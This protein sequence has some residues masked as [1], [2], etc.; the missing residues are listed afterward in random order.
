[1]RRGLI[2]GIPCVALCG[3]CGGAGGAG[4]AGEGPSNK[5]LFGVKCDAFQAQEA[6]DLMAWDSAARANLDRLRKSGVVVVRYEKKGCDVQLELLPSCKASGTYRYAGYSANETK[7]AKSASEL[8]AALPLGASALAGKM[9]QGQAMRTD[10]MLVGTDSLK[11]DARISRAQLRGP[12]CERAT[13]VVS[14]VYLGGFALAVGKTVELEGK[15]SVFGVGAGA[16]HSSSSERVAS[17]GVADACHEAQT[18][19]KESKTCAVPLRV[20]LLALD[21]A[22]AGPAHAATPV[23]GGGPRTSCPAGMALIA[24][25]PLVSGPAKERHDVGAFCVD[26]TEVTSAEYAACVEKK[27]CMAPTS[28]PASSGQREFCNYRKAG[29]EKHP[30]N[31]VTYEEAKTY[32]TAQGKALPTEQELE[33]AARG[34]EQRAL[35]W[36]DATTGARACFD[37]KKEGTCEVG[38][39]PD[40]AT[41][42]GVLDLAGNVAEIADGATGGQIRFG[43]HYAKTSLRD[44]EP[45]HKNHGEGVGPEIGFRCVAR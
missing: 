32:C 28:G 3:A 22:T 16:S 40:G 33:L 18:S 27:Q 23:G 42:E 2:I 30:I 8:F 38:A 19:G 13:H 29:R 12:E 5:E 9:S 14:T 4:L 21:K 24:A 26:K 36:G 10:Y 25:A 11:A 45:T 17:E 31:C 43:G 6:P 34:R 41:P 35:P 37:R 7:V 39:T 44:L 1:M 20:G 15:A